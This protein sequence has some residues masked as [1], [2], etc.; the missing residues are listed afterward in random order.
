MD[1]KSPIKRKL[2]ILPPGTEVWSIDLQETI[3]CSNQ[4]YVTLINTT[5]FSDYVFVKKMIKLENM[6]VSSLMGTDCSSYL[7]TKNEFGTSLKKL[8]FVKEIDVYEKE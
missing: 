2:Y 8:T 1:N 7:P 6:M 3:K 4:I 5:T